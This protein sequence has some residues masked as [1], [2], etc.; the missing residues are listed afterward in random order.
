M[1]AN[2]P[3]AFMNGFLS[4]SRNIFLT[5]SVGIAM[6]GFSNTF[7]LGISVNVVKLIS[8]IIFQFS[9]LLGLNTLIGYKRYYDILKKD[10]KNVPDYV[11]FQIWNNFL[12]ITSIY[13]VI[14]FMIIS[15]T[16][17]RLYNRVF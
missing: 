8:I 12:Y 17:V 2:N 11:D 4:G 9:F 3:Q 15:V 1:Y 6:Y 16:S 14:L 5:S 7:K 13:L 10:K